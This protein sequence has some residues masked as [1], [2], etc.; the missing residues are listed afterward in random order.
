MS[1]AKFT[2]GGGLRTSARVGDRGISFVALLATLART[3]VD[4]ITMGTTAMSVDFDHTRAVV[5]K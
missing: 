2:P 3:R 1:K 4:D 5:G